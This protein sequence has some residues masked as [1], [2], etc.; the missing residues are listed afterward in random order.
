MDDTRLGAALVLCSAVGFGTLGILGIVA[1]D[2][3]LSIP[4]ILSFRFILATVLVWVVFGL[5]GEIRLLR[6]RRFVAGV[7][8]GS[9]GYAAVSGLYFLGLGVMTAGMA[10]IV[11]YT[12]PAFVLVLSAAFLDEPIGRRRLSALVI[13]IGGIALITGADPAAADPR[14]IAVVLLAAILYAAY[15][16]VSRTTL[17]EVTPP[18]LTAHV[19]PAAA[20]TFLLVG[21]ATDTL[22]V[23]SGA[24]AWG[25]VLGIAVL[26]TAIPIFA[27]FAGLSR[28]GAGPASILSTVEPVATVVLGA[29]F[30]AE[31]VGPAV[32]A[33][34]SLVLVGV[35]L[36]AR[37]W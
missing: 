21:A 5:R 2:A 29:V 24:V 32:V 9:V 27:F 6:G 28:I 19:M 25:S 4:T 36:V 3:G 8:L 20:G 1:G 30:L 12:Y 23:P 15:I 26:A 33:G 14:G 18:T 7:G 22:G 35:V 16:T 37:T 31:P 13:T 17:E 34:G 11:L 10:G